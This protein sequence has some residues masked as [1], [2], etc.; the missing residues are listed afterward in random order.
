M[1]AV[2][3]LDCGGACGSVEVAPGVGLRAPTNSAVSRLSADQSGMQ[4]VEVAPLFQIDRSASWSRSSAAAGED[5]VLLCGEFAFREY[6]L[7]TQRGQLRDLVGGA[8]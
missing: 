7:V 1:A 8:R 3:G 2:S 6:A 4:L 5:L